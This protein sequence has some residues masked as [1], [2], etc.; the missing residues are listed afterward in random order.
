M[1]EDLYA[2]KTDAFEAGKM[3]AASGVHRVWRVAHSTTQ[4]GMLIEWYASEREAD[5]AIR[6]KCDADPSACVSK[7][8][9]IIPSSRRGLV[10]WLNAW[11]DTDNG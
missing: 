8:C 7:E 1:V 5:Q 10:R 3:V 6:T 11:F 4:E 2:T 9:I